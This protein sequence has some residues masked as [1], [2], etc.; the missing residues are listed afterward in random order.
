MEAENIIKC[1][2]GPGE[3]SCSV[4]ATCQI[5]GVCI[6]TSVHLFNMY[7]WRHYI[8]IKQDILAC[9]QKFFWSESIKMQV[10][11]YIYKFLCTIIHLKIVLRSRPSDGQQNKAVEL[12][13]QGI[14]T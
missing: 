5:A 7:L 12:R 13:L 2:D 10:P 4:K 1:I 14:K 6:R 3:Q 8:H 11:E 9:V